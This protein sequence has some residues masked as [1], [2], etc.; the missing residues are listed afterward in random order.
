M[1]TRF[2]LDYFLLC[3][4]FLQHMGLYV[5][6]SWMNILCVCL[7]PCGLNDVEKMFKSANLA[8]NKSLIT[9]RQITLLF[10]RL[11]QCPWA[12][13]YMVATGRLWA[14]IQV[15]V[16]PINCENYSLKVKF[17]TK[18]QNFQYFTRL[19]SCLFNF[20]SAY[21]HACIWFPGYDIGVRL[22]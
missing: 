9:F 6:H 13:M 7:G 21:G 8:K 4:I 11:W 17:W 15:H 20:D 12:R 22:S 18:N 16:V 19:L 1:K 3:H 2:F 14:Y 10:D 5:T